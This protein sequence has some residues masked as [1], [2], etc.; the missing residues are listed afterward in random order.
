MTQPKPASLPELVQAAFEEAGKKAI[1]AAKVAGTRLVV[2][3]DGRI[4]ELDPETLQAASS[5]ATG[6]PNHSSGREISS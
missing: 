1:A 3:R 5:Q 6:S 4:V 2:W